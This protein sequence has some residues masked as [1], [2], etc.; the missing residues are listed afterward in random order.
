MSLGIIELFFQVPMRPS[1]LLGGVAL[2]ASTASSA[3][4]NPATFA[5]TSF[6]FIVVGGGTTGAIVAVR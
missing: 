5:N 6:D 2:L 3:I 1:T 4:V